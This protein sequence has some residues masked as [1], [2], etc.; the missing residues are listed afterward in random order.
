MNDSKNLILAVVLSALVLLGWTWAANKYF[1]TANPP[2]TKVENGKQAAAA[3]AAGA[4]A[5][6]PTPEG[7]AEP[8]ARCSASTPRVADR[9]AVAAGLDQPQGRAD[10]R[11]RAASR[12]RQ[13]IDKNSP[14]VRLLSPLGAP[15]AYV[16]QFG[17]TG[18]GRSGAG[19]RHGVDRRQQRPDARPAGHAE[20]AD[21]GR[22]A[23]S[24]QDRR[25][26]RLSVH[27]PAARRSTRSGKPVVV[28]PIG[29][30]SR[31]AKSARSRQLDQPR[32]ADRRVR[33]QG[34]L[35]RRLE[36]ARR[37]R[38]RRRSTTSAAGSA[39]PTNIG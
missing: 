1:P 38:Q 9:D 31:A 4:A 26:R 3:A 29:L 13:T 21:A 16:A 20:H 12:Q 32:R 5:A 24:D 35:R 36:D 23:L 37:G 30:V 34:R 22:R 18:R 25:R 28:R 19:P 7:A 27:R 8:R 39:S 6:P 17:W 10:R 14:P 11:P 15:G 2:S 33:R